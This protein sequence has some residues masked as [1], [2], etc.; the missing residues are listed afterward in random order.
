MSCRRLWRINLVLNFVERRISQNEIVLTSFWFVCPYINW[1]EG[2]V[3]AELQTDVDINYIIL[4]ASYCYPWRWLVPN[5][6]ILDMGALD[7]SARQDHDNDWS[8][9]GPVG[10]GMR[11]NRFGRSAIQYGVSP[12]SVSN[13]TD[14]LVMGWGSAPTYKTQS[15]SGETSRPSPPSSSTAIPQVH[16]DSRRTQDARIPVDVSDLP[17]LCRQFVGGGL[18]RV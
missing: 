8:S 18:S 7:A 4:I 13:R 1:V 5:I 3:V 17:S 9:P 10:N 14:Q 6:F 16:F 15:S 12:T 11:L 2:R